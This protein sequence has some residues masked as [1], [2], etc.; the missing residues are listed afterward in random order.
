MT[1]SVNDRE[2]QP[3]GH[4]LDIS[5]LSDEEWSLEN[6]AGCDGQFFK[7]MARLG[8]L[9][10][11]GQGKPVDSSPTIVSRSLPPLPFSQPG[12]GDYSNFEGN[13]WMHIITAEDLFTS[14]TTEPETTSTQSWREW[15]Q[16]RQ[17]L[18]TWQLDPTILAETNPDAPLLTPDQRMDLGNISES[19]RYPA[20]L[21]T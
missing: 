20:L 2:G 19:F 21:Y 4:H 17:T 1:A 6:L 9:N 11:L 10:V 8:R 15:R 7:T 12:E 14:E 5:A 3:Q 16:I 13:G 18:Q